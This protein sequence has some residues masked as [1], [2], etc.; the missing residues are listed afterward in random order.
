VTRLKVMF[1]IPELDRGGPDAVYFNLLRTLDLDHF[2]PS[3]VVT[4]P[5]GAYLDELPGHIKVLRT[6]ERRYPV[7]SVVEH[8]RAVRPDVVL[9]TL[10]MSF[11]CT[12]ARPFFPRHTKVV[13][14][15][16]NNVTGEMANVRS[17]RSTA[18]SSA[19]T[20]SYRIVVA[21]AD[22]VIAQSHAMRDDVEAQFGTRVARKTVVLPNPVD[23]DRLQRRSTETDGFPQKGHPQLVA[24]GRLTYQKGFD[25]LVDAFAEVRKRH[26]DARLWILGEGEEHDALEAQARAAG[27]ADAVDLLG[28]VRN[29]APLYR[30]AD[31]YVCSSRYE[32]FPN[33]VAEALALGTPVVVPSGPAA[34]E[35]LVTPL[36]GSIVDDASGP[37]LAA[38]VLGLLDRLGELDPGRIAA[39]CRS[40]FSLE[41]V[42]RRYE[43]V[44][45]S[46]AGRR[47]LDLSQN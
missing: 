36:N 42:T 35:E 38:A 12:A 7:R 34:G 11:T 24:A 15:I 46:T 43:A 13:C 31:L 25:R 8:T 5:T 2:E 40:R 16:A 19:I 3:L 9:T 28:G 41:A 30:A 26:P 4:K 1:C 47:P 20:A 44:L 45:W 21:T 18:K 10:R 27:V 14:R 6:D 29:P 23:A 39:D 37:G 17:R 22:R 32:G 33:A